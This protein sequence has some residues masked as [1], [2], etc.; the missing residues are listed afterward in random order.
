MAG[1]LTGEACGTCC[2]ATGTFWANGTDCGRGGVACG[3]FCGATGIFCGLACGVACGIA[4]GAT[5]LPK[6]KE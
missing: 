2:G 4:I 1:V 3:T 6:S 5:E